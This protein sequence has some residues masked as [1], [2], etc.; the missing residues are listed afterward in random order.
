M[1]SIVE[2]WIVSAT[3]RLATGDQYTGGFEIQYCFDGYLQ[4]IL[5]FDRGRI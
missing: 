5:L 2:K 1:T 3:V 4:G